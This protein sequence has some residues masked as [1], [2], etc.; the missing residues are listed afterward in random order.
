[1]AN[2]ISSRTWYIDT[3]SPGVIF[4][5]QLFIKFI[6]VVAPA[7]GAS[8]IGALM[9]SIKDR[10]GKP[11]IT[12][13]FQTVGPGE[14]QTYNLENWFEGLIVDS[15]SASLAVTLRVHVK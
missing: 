6:E 11:I 14:V 4:Q 7:A 15:L 5:P 10:N 2:D 1:M 12:A 3:A 8:T 9:A 13:Q